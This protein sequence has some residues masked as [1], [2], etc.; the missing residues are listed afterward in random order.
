MLDS[1]TI[2]KS[3]PVEMLGNVSNQVSA[4]DLNLLNDRL[5]RI[6]KQMSMNMTVDEVADMDVDD[7]MD[8]VNKATAE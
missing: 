4:K 2:S 8:E 1:E 7:V 6:E 5:A 3:T